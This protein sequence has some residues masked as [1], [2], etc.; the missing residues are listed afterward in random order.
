MPQLYIAHTNS[1]AGMDTPVELSRYEFERLYA[2]ANV[3]AS[4]VSGI[5][6]KLRE[7]QETLV[8]IIELLRGTGAADEK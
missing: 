8:K 5:N 2:F 4:A 1:V 6:G 7:I 3:T